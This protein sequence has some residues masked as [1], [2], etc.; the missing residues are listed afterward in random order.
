[1]KYTTEK[2]NLNIVFKIKDNVSD[3]D[4]R[5]KNLKK[6]GNNMVLGDITEIK[7]PT[8]Y[9]EE[10]NEIAEKGDAVNFLLVKDYY[11][12]IDDLEAAYDFASKLF[13][14]NFKTLN[15]S[16]SRINFYTDVDDRMYSVDINYNYESEIK[17]SLSKFV[18]RSF[19]VNQSLKDFRLILS[20]IFEGGE[21]DANL[22]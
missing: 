3:D 8:D 17:V 18:D 2:E 10:V 4:L 14:P 15:Y 13:T 11:I 21:E 9:F 5:S 7:E 22:S 19:E 16:L 20:N 12:K 1:M 6:I